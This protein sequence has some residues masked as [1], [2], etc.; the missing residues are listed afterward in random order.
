M[1]RSMVDEETND[2]ETGETK[3]LGNLMIQ[4]RKICNHPFLILT[5]SE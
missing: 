1:Y 4:L 2:A 5:N 3:Q